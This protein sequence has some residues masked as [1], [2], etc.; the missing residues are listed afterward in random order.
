MEKIIIINKI[1]FFL[2]FKYCLFFNLES[3]STLKHKCL[4]KIFIFTTIWLPHLQFRPLLP[5]KF[6]K[7]SE[8]WCVAFFVAIYLNEKNVLGIPAWSIW[9]GMPNIQ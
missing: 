4:F 8:N 9:R 6:S 7:K 1:V 2:I 5:E 3:K